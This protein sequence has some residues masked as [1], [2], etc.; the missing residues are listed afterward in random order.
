MSNFELYHFPR[1]YGKSHKL[2]D[3]MYDIIYRINAKRVLIYCNDDDMVEYLGDLVTCNL[4]YQYSDTKRFKRK[5]H[6]KFIC[7]KNDM[8]YTIIVGTYKFFNSSRRKTDEEVEV[9]LFDE[10]LYEKSMETM[11]FIVNKYPKAIF[12]SFYTSMIGPF[13]ET[14][15][16]TFLMKE[17]GEKDL[18][19]IYKQYD[20]EFVISELL[21][22]KGTIYDSQIINYE[23]KEKITIDKFE[24]YIKNLNQ[25]DVSG[26][27]TVE[28]VFETKKEKLLKDYFG[29]LLSNDYHDK[30]IKELYQNFKSR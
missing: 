30:R 2:I 5:S 11:E 26:K 20:K 16:N 15:F 3:E 9:V 1:R 29:I 6:N 14:I 17:Y 18:E 19:N 22:L 10:L 23:I 25:K 4:D 24:K 8:K 28:R 27:D 21:R 13:E 12:K 7:R